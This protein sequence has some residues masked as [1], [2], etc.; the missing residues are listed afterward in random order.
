MTHGRIIS[1]V[2][3]AGRR[4][5]F[6]WECCSKGDGENPKSQENNQLRANEEKEDDD[7]DR[8]N[9]FVQHKKSKKG[10]TGKNYLLLNNQS[11]V[12]QVANPNLLKNIRKGEKPILIYCNAGL[13]NTD[14]IEELGR[15]TVHHNPRSIVNVLFHKSVVARH[16][17]TY[18]STECGGGV[19]SSH[20]R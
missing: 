6:A 12:N 20:P 7:D 18:N 11:T 15:M 3:I 4:G 16:C 2:I 5:I 10:V 14:L 9:L 13:T 19:S 17:M 1:P 8:E